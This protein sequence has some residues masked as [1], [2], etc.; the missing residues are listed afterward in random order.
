MEENFAEIRA[1]L[2]PECVPIWDK[3]MSIDM[4]EFFTVKKKTLPIEDW[5]GH[6]MQPSF[7]AETVRFAY[8]DWTPREGDV[9][10]VAYP[11]TGLNWTNE[12][13]KQLLYF[14]QERDYRIMSSQPMVMSL[15]EGGWSE[16]YKIFDAMPLKRRILCTHLPAPVINVDKIK[17][18]N[19]KVVYVLRNPKDQA[20]SW[21]NFIPKLP[22]LQIEPLD[23][24]FG[25]DWAT[26][27]DSFIAGK[28]PIGMRDGEWYLDHILGW[29]QHRDDKNVMFFYYEDM[30]QN[31]VK[32][33]SRMAKFLDLNLT[34]ENIREV[35]EKVAFSSMKKSDQKSGKKNVD[36]NLRNQLGILRKGEVGGWKDHFTVAQSEQMDKEVKNKL[37]NTDIKFKY[38][39]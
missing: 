10:V 14:G 32:E 4:S 31:P 27:L 3:M 19:A 28:M 21:F 38:T 8:E 30:K 18:V 16:K 6:K 1:L 24:L 36:Q 15:I 26:F 34:E 7:K 12:I 37:G 5:K 17:K 9:F 35:A 22:N 13:V 29:L 33:F 25:S 11:K 39:L 23:K 2:P 20:V